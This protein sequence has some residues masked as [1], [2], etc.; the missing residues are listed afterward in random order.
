MLKMLK[1]RYL[2]MLNHAFIVIVCS[3]M[4]RR[5]IQICVKYNYA[6]WQHDGFNPFSAGTIFIRQNLSSVDVRF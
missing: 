6:L 4:C 1:K 2:I 5:L 3:K